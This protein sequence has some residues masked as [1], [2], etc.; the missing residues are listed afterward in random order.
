MTRSHIRAVAF[1]CFGT[2][3][4]IG[5]PT[6]PWRSLLE[7]AHRQPGDRVLDPR[8]EPIA[9]IEAF[10]EACGIGFRPEWHRDLDRELAS[11]Q[12]MPD[13]FPMLGRLRAAGFRLALASNLAPAYV[14]PALRLLGSRVDV[15][16]FSCDPDVRAVK[17]ERAFFEALQNRLGLPAGEILMVG[18]SFTSD[19]RGAEAAGMPALH[20]VPGESLP[21]PGQIARLADVPT[22]LGLA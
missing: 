18:D 20:L 5:A 16:C 1:D 15:T 19:I 12:P 10:A 17:P 22:F 21:R 3:L 7:E 6:N 4:R 8:R 13:A 11:I 14:E 2:L 9:T